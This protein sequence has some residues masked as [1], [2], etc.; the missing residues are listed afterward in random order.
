ML[1]VRA[2]DAAEAI[3]IERTAADGAKVRARISRTGLQVYRNADGSERLEYRPESEVFASD[4]LASFRL[5]PVIRGHDWVTPANW[6]RLAIGVVATADQAPDPMAGE[7]W[8]TSELVVNDAQAQ[9]ELGTELLECSIA[10]SYQRCPESGIDPTTGRAYQFTQRQI[11]GNHL[12]LGPRNFAR[13][14]SQARVGDAL[15]WIEPKETETMSEIKKAVVVFD[16]ISVEQGSDTHISLMQKAIAAGESA[17][18]NTKTELKQAQDGLK[19]AEKKLSESEGKIVALEAKAKDAAD[20]DGAKLQA[21]IANEL[22]F[23]DRIRSV[24]GNDFAFA[25]KNADGVEIPLARTDVLR[26]AI[27]A[28]KP[29]LQFA[30]DGKVEYLQA[31]FDTIAQDAVTNAGT[32]RN[33]SDGVMPETDWHSAALASGKH[34]W[35]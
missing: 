17:L 31:I 25:V 4:S 20:E 16:G 3:T 19:E 14:G 35:A 7:R 8:V 24:V 5:M 30:A 11:R 33:N 22:A 13:A 1:E 32:S 10:Y 27:K 18:Q 12:G 28:A 23:R 34:T 29:N 9:E 6:R 21:A 26:A 2:A 15:D